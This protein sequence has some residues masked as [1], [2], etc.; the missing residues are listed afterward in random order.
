MIASSGRVYESGLLEYEVLDAVE[1]DADR[2]TGKAL[3]ASVCDFL[4]FREFG[5]YIRGFPI[6]E[7][8]SSHQLQYFHRYQSAV[9]TF[10]TP[11][12]YQND[13]RFR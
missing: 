7:R 3:Y 11:S 1:Q 13:K 6:P 12:I 10:T 8:R 5:K 2:L 4:H 9:S